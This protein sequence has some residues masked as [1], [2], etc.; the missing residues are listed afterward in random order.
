MNI[1]KSLSSKDNVVIV[2]GSQ[3][4]G[5]SIT[6]TS[7]GNTLIVD[8]NSV[9]ISDCKEITISIQGDVQ[10]VETA[11]GNVNII[12]GANIVSTVSGDIEIAGDVA[13]NVKTVSGDVKVKG[14]VGGNIKTVSGDV[15]HG[16]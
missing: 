5:R 1:F 16:H 12:G 7:N 6:I 2:N 4:V 9:N 3:Y 14:S 15:S 10:S 8:G 11:S 13:D